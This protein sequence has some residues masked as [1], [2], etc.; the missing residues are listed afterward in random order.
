MAEAGALPFLYTFIAPPT[1]PGLQTRCSNPRTPNSWLCVPT[2]LAKCHRI[3]N[4]GHRGSELECRPRRAPARMPHPKRT[5][6][7]H[8]T[9]HT[10]LSS[11]YLLSRTQHPGAITLSL[12]QP[13]LTLIDVLAS[14]THLAQPIK[15]SSLTTCSGGI[16]QTLRVF[17]MNTVDHL[18]SVPLEV[19]SQPVMFTLGRPGALATWSSRVSVLSPSK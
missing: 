11:C 14:P 8:R 15:M 10:L 9:Y 1:L 4:S 2:G 13:S 19:R 6:T 5:R 12:S 16:N 3:C 7:A 18:P 17:T